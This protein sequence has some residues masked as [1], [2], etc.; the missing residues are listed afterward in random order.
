M[1]YS[2]ILNNAKNAMVIILMIVWFSRGCY[3]TYF[4]QN[5]TLTTAFST[6][7]KSTILQMDFGH[8]KQYS[9][10]VVWIMVESYTD[11]SQNILPKR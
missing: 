5:R 3:R 1:K 2:N 4:T 9:T 11:E 7:I 10:T 6:G 8:R